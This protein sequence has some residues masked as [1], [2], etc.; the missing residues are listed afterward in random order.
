MPREILVAEGIRQHLVLSPPKKPEES[1]SIVEIERL[2]EIEID[3][4][5][6]LEPP[7]K[8]NEGMVSLNAYHKA[9]SQF[10]EGISD[11]AIAILEYLQQSWE[12][13][14]YDISKRYE[15]FI[16]RLNIDQ[17]ESP[18]IDEP[19]QYGK[20]ARFDYQTGKA[21]LTEEPVFYLSHPS[22]RLFLPLMSEGNPQIALLKPI[23]KQALN[24]Y[25]ESYQKLSIY[26]TNECEF[27]EQVYIQADD[28]Y[29]DKRLSS[30]QYISREP[31]LWTKMYWEIKSRIDL[32]DKL[33]KIA[34]S[35]IS[36][37]ETGQIFEEIFNQGEAGLALL[38][39][40]ARAFYEFSRFGD[41]ARNELNA[42]KAR[43]RSAGYTLAEKFQPGV[44]APVPD[45]PDAKVDVQE[46]QIYRTT[47]KVFK[48]STSHEV[49]KTKTRRGRC[50]KKKTRRWKE[51]ETR[52]HQ[53]PYTEWELIDLTTDPI[54]AKMDL[55][56]KTKSVYFMTQTDRGFLSQSGEK[57]ENI[58]ALCDMDENARMDTVIVL[59][60]Y[61]PIVGELEN[62]NGATFY[63]CPLPGVFPIQFPIVSFQ[64]EIGYKLQWT[65]TELGQLVGSLNLA[66]GEE[67][68]ITASSKFSEE[69]TTTSSYK[70]SFSSERTS[71]TDFS[72]EL[73][74][75]A[76]KELTKT[77]TSSNSA[78]VGGSY[79][80]VSGGASAKSSSSQ[81]LKQFS[82]TMRKAARKASSSVSKK[83]SVEINS[84]FASKTLVEQ[85]TSRTTKV[86]NVNKGS[87][88]NLM[89]YQINNRFVG[90][91]YLN[92]LRISITSGRE[93]IAGSG[94]FDTEVFSFS[95]IDDALD[96]MAPH[97][98][99]PIV[100]RHLE[101][102]QSQFHPSN[103]EES[104][105]SELVEERNRIY[106]THL[107]IELTK[108][109]KREYYKG[110][111]DEEETKFPIIAVAEDSDG[112]KPVS[113][114]QSIGRLRFSDS[115]LSFDNVF[116]N[117]PENME[118]QKIKGQNELGQAYENLKAILQVMEL[119][120]SPLDETE[121]IVASGG[122]WMDCAV[123]EGGALDDY[124]Q[125]MRD[126][127]KQ[128]ASVELDALVEA[129]RFNIAKRHA[130][131]G[132]QAFGVENRIIVNGYSTSG[133]SIT[134]KLNRSVLHEHWKVFFGAHEIT[135]ISISNN[136]SQSALRLDFAEH[137]EFNPDVGILM[138]SETEDNL[139]IVY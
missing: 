110:K 111:S 15:K 63:F 126:I 75:E 128:K 103:P 12:R 23:S 26:L 115:D 51:I 29:L 84:S 135:P 117:K 78:N 56:S 28:S 4:L 64:E 24:Q 53:K 1:P 80:P 72:E 82:K 108:T 138:L 21:K 109:L 66:P 38:D 114:D 70:Q 49:W 39:K 36:E 83:N 85:S 50:G 136:E 123:G 131:F 43:V 22:G 112:V 61:S 133:N 40:R 8:S 27:F 11:S 34:E 44:P 93:I 81:T 31:Y 87:T 67:R 17:N 94:I 79:G 46:G 91:M 10:G 60:D 106:W 71:T 125:S 73:S 89:F 90:G 5:S 47:Q 13:A 2:R 132:G 127:E 129:N 48:W 58:M 19:F 55:L 3:W 102:Y 16:A 57:L 116:T 54:Q 62:Y 100:R 30:T 32:G 20:V 92:D 130:V 96:A 119:E 86:I 65:G 95:E 105:F 69:V 99:P 25:F 88:L 45:N 9:T 33:K 42:L 97:H 37:P 121:L 139:V 52:H 41:S 35:K 74:R 98:L 137:I 6:I 104:N 76:G 7:D 118:V 68:E 107:L 120:E 124:S 101:G 18:V 14:G 122:I 77:K 59:P 113:L 134:L